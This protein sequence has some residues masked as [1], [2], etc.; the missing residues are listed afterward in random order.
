MSETIDQVPEPA[1][2]DAPPPSDQTHV[3][4]PAR[5]GP[6]ARLTG[7]LLSPGETFVD[8]NRKP[9]WIAPMIVAILTVLAATVFF[10]WRVHPDWDSIFRAQIRKQLEKTNQSLTDEQL[11]QRVSI[12]KSIAKFSPIIAA[13]FTPISY[14]VLA[15]I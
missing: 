8:V 7:V 9:T 14:V 6:L 13:V 5:L 3:E 4:E 2:Y 11:E 15:G 10:Q 12:S 1:P